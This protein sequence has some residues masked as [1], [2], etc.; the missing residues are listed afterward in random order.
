MTEG[1]VISTGTDD[2]VTVV[3]L[4]DA[5]AKIIYGDPD[6]SVI[7][8]DDPRQGPMGP[9]YPNRVA[10]S[11]NA[12]F[13]TLFT[14]GAYYTIDTGSTNAPIAGARWY[15]WIEGDGLNPTT[16]IKQ[17]ATQNDV[18]AETYVRTCVAGTF[19][20]WRQLTTPSTI[21]RRNYLMSMVNE[22]KELN[23]MCI[24]IGK[25]ADGYK[26]SDGINVASSLSY[27][28]DT[29]G[30]KV[31]QLAPGNDSFSKLL[32][33]LDTNFADTNAGGSSKTFTAGGTGAITT[34]QAKFG[35]GSLACG[36]G[37]GW[38]DTPDS[39]DFTIGANPFTLEAWFYRSGGDGTLRYICG[40]IDSAGQ[41]SNTVILIHLDTGNKLRGVFGTG[42]ALFSITGST[43]IVATG[44]HHVA[45]VKSGNTLKLFLD[46]VADAA[47]VTSSGNVLDGTNKF[48]VGRGGELTTNGWNGF[49]DSVH[50]SVGVA[51][52]L[53]NFT[54]RLVPF[55]TVIPDMTVVSTSIVSDTTV[56]HARTQVEFDNVGAP[57]L[58]TDLTAEVT[59]DAGAHWSA[60]PLS[61]IMTSGPR[62]HRI[63]ESD[64]MAVTPGTSYAVRLKT[65]NGKNVP[66]YGLATEV[67]A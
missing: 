6:V 12:N 60:A 15:V 62:S 41:T 24:V 23:S 54:P 53:A 58:N 30:G 7:S 20:F 63:V 22:A 16:Y 52:Y 57:T 26:G 55:G 25:A 61:V 39:A 3:Y 19:G 31:S 14:P 42:A 33:Q 50:L 9:P 2:E 38:I 18:T 29:A 46:G 10:L 28:L 49:I 48:A 56:G 40:Q 66:I 37:A 11:A 65:I 21:D 64:L 34:S 1:L 43:S 4:E 59:C 36:A 44:W 13:N 5:D 17:M 45:F 27:A 32:L 51:R 47:D 35:I 67:S 8:V